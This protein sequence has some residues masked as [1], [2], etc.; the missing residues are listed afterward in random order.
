MNIHD[1]TKE[2]LL[3]ESLINITHQVLTERRESLTL[4]E[5]MEEFRKLT[6]VSEKELKAKMLQFYTDLNIDGRFLAIQDNRWGLREWYPVDQIEEETAPVVKVR[7]KK[8]KKKDYDEDD[9]EEED[10]DEEIFDEEYVELGEEDDADDEEE[11][12]EEVVGLEE[13]LID[14]DDDLEVIPEV[15]LDIDEEDEEDEEED[16][17]YEEEK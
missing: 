9:I 1:M 13:D 10:D 16:D 3:E 4:A 11:E 2:E 7:K 8:K 17:E 14:P 6:G 12:E 5:L 15:E